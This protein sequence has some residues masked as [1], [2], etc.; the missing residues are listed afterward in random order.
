MILIS[1][2]RGNMEYKDKTS[3]PCAHTH[4]TTVNTPLRKKETE[5]MNY[6]KTQNMCKQ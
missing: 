3:E 4:E 2:I 1:E 5:T 6:D